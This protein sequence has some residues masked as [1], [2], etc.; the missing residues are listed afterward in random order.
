MARC[1]VCSCFQN[2]MKETPGCRL[3]LELAYITHSALKAWWC[4]WTQ[5]NI[6]ISIHL[7]MTLP[8]APALCEECEWQKW[9]E[10]T[11]DGNFK[12]SCCWMQSSD[13]WLVAGKIH[14][15]TGRL[16]RVVFQN[17]SLVVFILSNLKEIRLMLLMQ[18][19]MVWETQ[20]LGDSKQFCGCKRWPKI[21][22]SQSILQWKTCGYAWEMVSSFVGS[23]TKSSQE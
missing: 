2:E 14:L 13:S 20:Q 15:L 12:G 23:S 17:T 11:V 16:S 5:S 3:S 21:S 1:T 7:C 22:P 19:F 9:S 6:C 18:L 10:E 8:C 4:M